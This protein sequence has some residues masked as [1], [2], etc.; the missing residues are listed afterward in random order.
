MDSVVVMRVD[1]VPDE[2]LHDKNLVCLEEKRDL[3]DVSQS[4]EKGVGDGSIG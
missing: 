4:I 3:D 2:L 1:S